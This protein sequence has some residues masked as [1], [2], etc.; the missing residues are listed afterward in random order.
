MILWSGS[1]FM[2]GE[3][4]HFNGE[5]GFKKNKKSFCFN[6]INVTGNVPQDIESRTIKRKEKP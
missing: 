5:V 3:E 6:D 2:N 1:E 4:I